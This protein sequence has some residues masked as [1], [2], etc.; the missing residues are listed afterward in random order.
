GAL[1]ARLRPLPRGGA[2]AVRDRGPA[3]RPLLAGGAGGAMTTL[4]EATGVTKHF[5]I[6]KGLFGTAKGVVHAVDGVSFTIEAGRTLG[7][8]GESGCG[9]STTAKLV[10]K[11]EEPTAGEIR[12]EGRSPQSL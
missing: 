4:L 2:A 8:V 3:H 5:P 12:L 11:L 9:K 10:L 7:V 1:S 6:R